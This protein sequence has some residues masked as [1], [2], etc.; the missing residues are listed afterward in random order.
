MNEFNSG[1]NISYGTKMQRC[2]L[3]PYSLSENLDLLAKLLNESYD[4]VMSLEPK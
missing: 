2:I 4:Y 3:I 1:Y